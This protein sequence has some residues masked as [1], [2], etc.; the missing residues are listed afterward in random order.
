[1]RCEVVGS[2][3]TVAL[4]NPTG[5]SVTT[6]GARAQA[7]PADWRVR[8]DAAYH[9]E[10]QEWVDGVAAGVVAGPSAW[11]GYAATAVGEACVRA[12]ATGGRV[13]VD[14]G[15]QPALYARQVGS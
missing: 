9:V 11:D 14:L 10:L 15:A 6:A 13:E 5:S 12:L 8:F 3:G 7:V 4:E 2:D 1:M